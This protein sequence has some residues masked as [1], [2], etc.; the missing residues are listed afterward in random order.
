[1]KNSLITL[2]NQPYCLWDEGVPTTRLASRET[3]VDKVFG[4]CSDCHQELCDGCVLWLT[5]LV[6]WPAAPEHG[7]W[8]SCSFEQQQSVKWCWVWQSLSCSNEIFNGCNIF[9]LFTPPGIIYVPRLE[10]C[11][12]KS[13]PSMSHVIVLWFDV[14]FDGLKPSVCHF[15]VLTGSSWWWECKQN[16]PG[17]HCSS[18]FSSSLCRS[19]NKVPAWFRSGIQSQSCRLRFSCGVL[20]FFFSFS[21]AVWTWSLWGWIRLEACPAATVSVGTKIPLGQHTVFFVVVWNNLPIYL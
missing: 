5:V 13:L 3:S 12:Y 19:C 18:R 15:I 7:C 10:L 11:F 14:V 20:G 8:Q 16:N 2:W 9:S 21:F 1:M 6:M 17:R 4:S